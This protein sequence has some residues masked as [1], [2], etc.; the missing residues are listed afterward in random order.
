MGAGLGAALGTGLVSR[1]GGGLGMP[2]SLEMGDD[3][4]S[5]RQHADADHSHDDYE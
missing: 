4:H 1:P 5:V 2:R 3:D